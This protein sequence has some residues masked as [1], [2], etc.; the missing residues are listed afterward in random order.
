MRRRVVVENSSLIHRGG[1]GFGMTLKQRQ[2][3]LSL[4]FSMRISLSTAARQGTHT[5]T[6]ALLGRTTTSETRSAFQPSLK[7]HL[8]QIRR[9]LCRCRSGISI[10]I[11]ARINT[12]R[13]KIARKRCA[14]IVTKKDRR[15]KN[16]VQRVAYRHHPGAFLRGGTCKR[17]RQR[18]RKDLPHPLWPFLSLSTL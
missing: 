7:Q 11:C 6:H 15:K 17:E 12:H 16:N 4:E 3:S 5:H 2:F 14:A 8:Q 9:A 18:E 10:Y 1:G 13:E